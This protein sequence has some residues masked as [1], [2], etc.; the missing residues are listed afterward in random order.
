[1][2]F[3]VIIT[4]A[5]GL[6]GEG[7]LF[8]CLDHP[9]V[10]EILIVGRK[11]YAG[12]KHDK[13][14]ECIVPD[15]FNLDNFSEQLSGYDAA[16]YC[17]GVSSRGMT[18]ASY[19]RITL[20][21]TLHF[22]QTLL[23]LNPEMVFSHVSGA[24]SDSTEQGSIMWARVKGKIEN[25]L[26]RMPFKAAYN[27]RPGFM[28][29]TNGQKNVKSYYKIISRM[30]PVLRLL[31]PRQVCTMQ[32]VGLAMINSVVKGYPKKTLEIADIKS[33]AGR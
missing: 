8:E 31:L 4:G 15:F 32:E 12:K 21:T 17:A 7:V 33:L 28:K 10:K 25:A 16:F 19:S 1:M 22:A 5:T 23:N 2:E 11:P 9:S 29:P 3:K 18:E 26:L 24:H 6:V 13:L 27:F 30:Y 20:D 14:K